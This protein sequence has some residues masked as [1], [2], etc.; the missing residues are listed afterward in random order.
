MKTT[1]HVE[2]TL[3]PDKPFITDEQLDELWDARGMKYRV[4][5]LHVALLNRGLGPYL[6]RPKF[7]K[8]VRDILEQFL[9]RGEAKRQPEHEVRQSFPKVF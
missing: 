3:P 2:S 4:D 8:M 1:T 9:V 5:E 7:R 6:D